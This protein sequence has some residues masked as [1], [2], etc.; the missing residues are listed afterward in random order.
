MRVS[1]LAD[2]PCLPYEAAGSGFGIGGMAADQAAGTYRLARPACDGDWHAY[3]AIRRSV[4]FENEDVPPDHAED[5]VPGNYPMLLWLNCEP[6]G[7]IRIDSLDGG[8]A[9]FRL[10]AIH[11]DCQGQGHGRIL[12]RE[13]E[14]FAREI[15]CRKAVIYSTLEAAGF[16]ATAGYAED[17]WDDQYFSGVVLMTKPLQYAGFDL[18]DDLDAPN[19]Q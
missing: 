16:Y 17:E 7:A 19:G 12:L 5:L 8:G 10:V 13:A 1:P 3:H 15:G 11:P 2:P 18:T 14:A 4:H 9:A 6:V